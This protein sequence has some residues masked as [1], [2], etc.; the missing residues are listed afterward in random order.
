[1]QRL[2]GDRIAKATG[3]N[4]SVGIPRE[5]TGLPCFKKMSISRIE[6]GQASRMLELGY[7]KKNR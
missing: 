6:L 2:L 1:M 4:S 3:Y 7:Q 5:V